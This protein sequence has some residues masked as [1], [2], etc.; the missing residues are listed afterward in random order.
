MD[1]KSKVISGLCDEAHATY[2]LTTSK[3]FLR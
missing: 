2:Y 3:Y 1:K